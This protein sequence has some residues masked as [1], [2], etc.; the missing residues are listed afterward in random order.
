MKIL[1]TENQLQNVSEESSTPV[2]R[3]MN[4]EDLKQIIPNLAEVFHKT[5][6]SNIQVWQLVKDEFNVNK[7]A[8]MLVGNNVVGFY[9][10]GDNQIPDNGSETYQKLNKMNGVEGVALGILPRYKEMGLGKQLII[11]SQNLP[12]DYIWGYQLKSLENIDDWKKRR[13]VYYEDDELYITYQVLNNKMSD[14]GD[15]EME[16]NEMGKY[17]MIKNPFVSEFN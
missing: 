1:I 6:L 2:I 5:K 16:M 10:I 4:K 8:V 17:P 3:Q 13:K 14:D 12:I 15:F 11:W 9:F 7:S